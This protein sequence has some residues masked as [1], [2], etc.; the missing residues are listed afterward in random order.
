MNI[1]M[2]SYDVVD[3]D[4]QNTFPECDVVTENLDQN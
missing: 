2:N 3:K 4:V 1:M